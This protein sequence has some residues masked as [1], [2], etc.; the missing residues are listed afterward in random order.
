MSSD[1]PYPTAS[2]LRSFHKNCPRLRFF[3]FPFSITPSRLQEYPVPSGYVSSHPLEELLADISWF[4]SRG[5]DTPSP[6][7]DELAE[8]WA[9]H[10]LALFPLLNAGKGSRLA[11]VGGW[12]KVCEAMQRI[13]EG[14]S[15]SGS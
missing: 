7:T 4:R 2:S 5:D 11:L 9:T 3:S 10:L 14:D 1:P 6:M 12:K 8:Q 15:G 13:R